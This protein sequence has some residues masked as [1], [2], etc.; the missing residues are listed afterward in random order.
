MKEAD[1]KEIIPPD[2]VRKMKFYLTS[3]QPCPYLPGKMERK[4]FANLAVDGAVNL[5]DSLTRSGFRRSQTIAY[6]PACKACGACRSVRIDVS[7]FKM[8][9]RW[10]RVLAR[11]AMLEREPVNARATREQFRLLKKYLNDRHPGGGM[12]EMEIRDYAGMVDASPVR[13]VVFEYRNRIEPGPVDDGV[14]QAAA[15]T[16]VLRDGLSMVYSFFRP[17]L[18]GRSVGSFMVLD[19][20]RLA[21][22]LGLPYVYL[23]YWVRGS[24]KMGYKADFQPLEVFDG[25]NWR[26]LLDEEI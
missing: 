2:F 9:K 26:P 24:D 10:K 8:S 20:I 23:G 5:N 3:P 11:N 17:E 7:A 13:T 1:T 25:E 19:H 14:L 15:L 12:T 22:E 6:R 4:V 21:S 18:S 16:D